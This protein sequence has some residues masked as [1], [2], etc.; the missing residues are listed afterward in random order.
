MGVASGSPVSAANTNQ[1]FIDANGD[2]ATIG[3]LGLQNTDPVSGTSVTNLQE[4]I[5]SIDS[6]TG[7]TINTLKN[8]LPSWTNNDVGTSTDSLVA[9]ADALTQKFN[10][11]AG[12]KH[13]GAAGDA[14]PV[15]SVD[16]ANVVLKGSFVAGVD[17]SAITGTSVDVS[18]QFTSSTPSSSQTVKGV[19]VTTTSDSN[20]TPLRQASGVNTGDPFEDGLGNQVYGRI[21]YAASVWTLSFYVLISGTETAYNFVSASDIRFYFQQ[22][23]NPIVDAPVYSELAVVPS[24]NTTADVIDA[25]EANAGKVL[26]SNVVAQSVGSANVKGTGTRVSKE[27]HVHQGVHSL[28][29]YGDA[30]KLFGD[31]D[32]EEGNSITLTRTGQRIKIDA[33][34]GVGFQEVPA[35][36]VNGVNNTFGPLSQLPSSTESV[37][38]FVDGLPVDKSK[39]TLSSYSIIFGSGFEPVSGQDV[40]CWYLSAGVPA[41]PPTPTGTLRTEFRT[42]TAPEAAAKIVV[43]AYTPAD[44]G[45][46]LVDIIGG[47]SQEFNVDYTVVSNEFRWN[48]YAL[49]GFLSSGDR[50]RIHYIT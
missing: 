26:L 39:W 21:T 15:S 24:E 4:E 20:K 36:P 34:G 22:L 17:L 33:G 41:V 44:P 16:L 19:C 31:I 6:Y 25:T 48:G 3:K 23:F 8:D 1:A 11:S 7:K 35:G 28:G 9:R 40:Y 50:L 12:H 18:S 47:T 32:L 37:I 14:P 45:G 38:V 2:D 29:V 49:D 30:T 10:A 46:V 5:N 43:L 27:D 13:T 42:I